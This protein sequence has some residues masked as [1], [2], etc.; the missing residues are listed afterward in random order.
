MEQPEASGSA[1]ARQLP[2]DR[3]GQPGF[4]GGRR[5]PCIGASARGRRVSCTRP[6][7]TAVSAAAGARG[8]VQEGRMRDGAAECVVHLLVRAQAVV[9]GGALGVDDLQLL[10]E[11]LLGLI[12]GLERQAELSRL[13]VR[14]Q[15]PCPDMDRNRASSRAH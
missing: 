7:S 10:A 13:L 2:P 12:G 11:R 5:A 14:G 3:L 4:M 6:V 9:E 8:E 1:G 15:R